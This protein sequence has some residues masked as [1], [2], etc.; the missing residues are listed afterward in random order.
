MIDFIFHN[1]FKVL[2]YHVMC[3]NCVMSEKQPLSFMTLE[4]MLYRTPPGI[5]M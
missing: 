3:G 5:F 1:F 2:E 4:R